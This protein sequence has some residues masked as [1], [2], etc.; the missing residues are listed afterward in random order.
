MPKLKCK[1]AAKECILTQGRDNEERFSKTIDTESSNSEYSDPELLIY[2]SENNNEEELD[3]EIEPNEEEAKYSKRTQQYKNKELQEAV[4]G[5][6]SL[7]NFFEPK[8]KLDIKYEMSDSDTS[9]L[10]ITNDSSISE[11]LNKLNNTLN[12]MKHMNAYKY[13]C[14]L[15]IYKYFTKIFDY[16]KPQSHIEL[17]LEIL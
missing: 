6:M 8:K 15:A 9:D 5:S 13:L 2:E 1:N 7:D 16:E 11:E 17:S 3:N 10:D 14:Y 12:N 4:Q